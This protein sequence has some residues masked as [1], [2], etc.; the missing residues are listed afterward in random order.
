[1]ISFQVGASGKPWRFSVPPQGVL[2]AGNRSR[3]LPSSLCRALVEGLGE[4]GFGFWVGCASGVDRCF[5]QALAESRYAERTFVG[6]AFEERVVRLGGGAAGVVAPGGTAAAQ[7]VS[8]EALL[9]GGACAGKPDDRSVG[10]GLAA[11]VSGSLRATEAGV[12][13]LLALSVSVGALPGSSFPVV[14]GAGLLGGAAS[15]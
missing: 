9:H 13:H 7:P 10:Q 15:G 8:G 5:R 11:G 14:W 1:M 6:C 4:A 12:P 2:F 3:S